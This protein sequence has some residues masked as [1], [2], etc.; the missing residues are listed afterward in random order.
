MPRPTKR[1]TPE[2]EAAAAVVTARG[3]QQLTT[4]Q[5]RALFTVFLW[6]ATGNGFV[7][8]TVQADGQT[9]IGSGSDDLRKYADHYGVLAD[10]DTM[11]TMIT[12][13]EGAIQTQFSSSPYPIQANDGSFPIG[14]VNFGVALQV[15]GE[16]FLKLSNGDYG[17]PLTTP[18][19]KDQSCTSYDIVG[20]IP[21]T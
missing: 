18:Y 16:L 17:A 15:V 20:M 11:T 5:T 13:L 19:P 7:T 14:S 4:D 10:A 1:I 21:T 6:Y 12:T 3:I 2:L 8:S 9:V